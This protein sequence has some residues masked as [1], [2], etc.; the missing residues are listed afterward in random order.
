MTRAMPSPFRRRAGARRRG[1]WLAGLALAGL[2]LADPASLCFA[3][4]ALAGD[5]G[6]RIKANEMAPAGPPGEV[7]RVVQPFGGWT[8][9]CDEDLKAR[10]K[11]CNVSQVLVDGAGRPAFNWSLAATRGGAPVI[12]MRAPSGGLAARHVGIAFRAGE[13]ATEY[14][15]PSCDAE[16]CLGLLPVS[17]TLQKRLR[18]GGTAEISLMHEGRLR[19]LD[20]P[21]KDLATA[22]AAVK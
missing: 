22:L 5:A 3:G 21:M 17:P 10:R 16:T 7:R 1:S 14:D 11:V 4:A 9:I 2:A 12:I 19:T 8:L 18:E 15:L 13:T 6:F 20:A